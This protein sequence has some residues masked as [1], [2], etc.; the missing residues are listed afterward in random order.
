MK[1]LILIS[2]S[3]GFILDYKLPLIECALQKELF[4]QIIVM[5]PNKNYLS[6][7]QKDFEKYKQLMAKNKTIFNIERGNKLS[8]IIKNLISISNFIWRCDKNDD[9]YMTSHTATVNLS[10]LL[11]SIFNFRKNIYFRYVITG[12]GPSKIRRGIRSRSMGRIYVKSMQIAS[13][14]I[15]QK[16]LTLNKQDRDIIQDFN[17]SRNVILVRES[18]I[19][20]E[21]LLEIKE[22]SKPDM[23]ILKIIYVG[24]FLLEKGISDLDVISSYL[25]LANIPHQFVAYGSL[26]SF[27]TSCPSVQNIV[28]SNKRIKFSPPVPYEQIFQKA[29]IAIFPSL[30]EGHPKLV[31]QS[32][33]F[34]CIP[35]AAPNPGLDVDILNGY[36]GLLAVT[37]S[38]SSIAAEVIKLTNDPNM[39][40]KLLKGCSSYVK[41]LSEQ[42]SNN[43]F[44]EILL[45]H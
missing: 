29:H 36:N 40:S 20:K 6:Y 2:N 24:R 28:N 44:L 37:S 14:L 33:L 22:T 7:Q 34:G 38:P 27:N 5:V 15:N 39:Y 8:S 16:V 32:M 3:F 41:N 21:N 13:S 25:K 1:K 26:D 42:S 45:K 4:N 19:A 12:F 35:I 17:P 43:E 11:S 9:I 10:L 18:G 23:S 31:L 30:R